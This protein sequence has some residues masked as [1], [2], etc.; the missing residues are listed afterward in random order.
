ML[1]NINFGKC[2]LV[3]SLLS[4]S[5]ADAFEGHLKFRH[6]IISL[7]PDCSIA[8]QQIEWLSS[9]KPTRAEL[10]DARNSLFFIGGFSKYFNE[11]RDVADGTIKWA[12]NQKVREIVE[13]CKN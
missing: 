10:T 5:T 6:E 9:L 13:E 8:K 3:V 7:K 1:S 4:A 2:V 11:N 12:V